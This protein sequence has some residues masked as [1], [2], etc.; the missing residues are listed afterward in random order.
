MIMFLY[1]QNCKHNLWVIPSLSYS[2]A[3]PVAVWGNPMGSGLGCTSCM[4]WSHA[5]SHVSMIEMY[6]PHLAHKRSACL[7][8]SWCSHSFLVSCLWVGTCGCLR[9][10][11]S[12]HA[13]VLLSQLGSWTLSRVITSKIDIRRN[14]PQCVVGTRVCCALRSSRCV[15]SFCV[16]GTLVCMTAS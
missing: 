1:N 14:F 3:D 8:S 7:Y 5:D 10:C 12:S 15:K 4:S 2:N 16:C 9:H 6:A 13:C 11:S